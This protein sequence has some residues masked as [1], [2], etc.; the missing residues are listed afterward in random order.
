MRPNS[1]KKIT[2]FTLLLGFFVFAFSTAARAA[3]VSLSATPTTQTVTVGQTAAYTIK[4]NRDNYAD[5]V[6]LSATGLPSG[7]TATFNPNVTTLSSS[8]LKLQTAASTPIGAFNINVKATANGITIAPIAVKLTTQ[9]APSISLTVTP[10]S[11]SIVAGQSTFYDIAVNRLNYDG[12]LTLSAENVP[13]GITIVFDPDATYGN[14]ARMYLYSNGLPFLPGVYGMYMRAHNLGDGIEKLVP[15]KV[16]VNYGITWAAQFGALNN[17]GADNAS[18]VTYDSAGNVYLTGYSRNAVTADNDSWVAKFDAAGN[19]LWLSIIQNLMDDQ[20][21]DVSVD[22]GGNVYVAGSTRGSSTDIFVAKFAANGVQILS[23]A[24]FGTVNEEGQRGMQFGVDMSGNTTLT[25]ATRVHISNNGNRDQHNEPATDGDYDITR[26]TFDANFNRTSTI[27]VAGAVGEPKDLTVG[28]DGSIYVLG[29]DHTQIVDTFFSRLLVVTSQVEKF[30]GQTGQSIYR[31]QPINPSDDNRYFGNQLKVDAQGNVFAVGTKF[32]EGSGVTASHIFVS[33]WFAKIGSTGSVNW[34]LYPFQNY[35]QTEIK[36]L[37]ID[38][39]GNVYC[40]GYTWDSLSGTNPNRGR[41]FD[42]NDP[43]ARSDA[44]FARYSGASGSELYRSQ[45]NVEDTDVF[46]A[47]KLGTGSAL[48]FAG[49]TLHFKNV[50][51]GFGDALL[52]RCNTPVC[53][54]VP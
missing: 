14:S 16:N 29:E 5:K 39:G 21:T 28:G 30:N 47:V 10:L 23:T 4:I 42:P 33:S 41:P 26:Y 1:F 19:R 20:A 15:F 52:V 31:S 7:V 44:F 9:P 53:G 22:V 50:N 49:T 27:V 2:F 45:F 11:Q 35:Y 32:V 8:T 25:A 37:D 18:D 36:A 48:Y 3:G 6:T 13:S 40:A 51:F 46:N 24:V 34:V 38:A 17:Q 54:Y 43:N 12:K